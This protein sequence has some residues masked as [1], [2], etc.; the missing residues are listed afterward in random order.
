[1]A[2]QDELL[3][4][5]K[6]LWTGGAE[7]YREHMDD[8][9]LVAFTEMAGAF[10]A[11]EIAAMAEEGERWEEPEM[12]VRGLVEPQDGIAMLTYR[13]QVVRGEGDPYHALVSSGYV[14]RSSG[15]KMMFHQQTPLSS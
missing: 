6:E 13:V 4:I 10:T 11:Q 3:T 15:W 12:E 14:R 2:I 5:E 9:C 8:R 1:M 7:A